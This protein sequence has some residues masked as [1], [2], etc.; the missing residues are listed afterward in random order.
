MIGRHAAIREHFL[1][2]ARACDDLGSP[3]TARLCGALSATLDTSTAAGRR[4]LDWP[5]DPRADALALRLC[6][7]LHA[8][9]LSEADAALMAVYPPAQTDEPALAR[10]L[11]GALERNDVKLLASLD[12]A[13]QTNEIGRSGMLLPGFLAIARETRLPLAL[14]EIG[15]SAGLNMLFDRFSYRYGDR[16]WGDAATAGYSRCLPAARWAYRNPLS[17]RL[18]YRASRCDRCGGSAETSLLCLGGPSRAARPAR[19]R[20]EPRG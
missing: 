2:Q 8:L 6:G 1:H 12:S 11:P 19:S 18:R 10:S 3:F 13:P 14:H 4:A 7:G 5:G 17:P 16:V 20:D 15:A 9:V